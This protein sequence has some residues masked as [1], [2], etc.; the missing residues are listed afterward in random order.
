M[1]Y[2][3]FPLIAED[4]ADYF[5]A[6]SSGL[7][8]RAPD[9]EKLSFVDWVRRVR[10]RFRW[11]RHAR[12][13]AGVLQRVADGELS[14]VMIFTE[15]RIGKS[16]EVSRLFSAYFL[17][18]YPERWVGLNSYAADL[19]YTLSRAARDNYRSSGG[20]VRR[21]VEAVRHWETPEGGGMWAAGVGGPITGKGFHL[22]LIDD[23]L[24]NA[25]E[26][27]SETIR[28]G[29]KEWYRSTF[30]TREEPDGAI[31]VIQTRW[32]E[33]DLSGWLLDEE[34]VESSA[35]EG[36]PERW[37]IV[38]LP[39]IKEDD[40]QEFPPTCTVEPDWRAAG[41][42]CCPER[43]PLEKL[44]KIAR[45]VGEYFWSALFMQRPSPK[46]GTVFKRESFEVVG[47]V[48]PG[49]RYVRYW[50][51][52]GTEG[53][54]A[55]SAGVLLAVASG[56]YYVVDVVRGQWDATA[57]NAVIKQTAALDAS[58]YGRVSIWLEQ[59][60]GSGGKESAQISV[61]DL[62]GYAAFAEPVTG[63]KLFRAQPLAAQAGVRNVKLVNAPERPSLWIA[64]YL[65]ELAAFPTGKYKD[66]VD[67]SSGAFNKLA[68]VG[69]RKLRET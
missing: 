40:A 57:R 5:E 20:Q 42:A 62:A 66:Q 50:D 12:V 65:D 44:K 4:L 26:A 25:E 41:E 17:Y 35:E 24:K 43:H 54:G 21:D 52:A 45:R 58:T 48:P 38:S 69:N 60:P 14:R 55:Y 10:P 64:K 59:E 37:H 36:Q 51:K 1:T 63:D 2:P 15:P 68:L 46:G 47:A 53:G 7:P 11:Y 16:E 13:I 29:H 30:Y 18:R 3:L 9:P 22:G 32:N 33:D 39:A 67:A 23:P 49:A 19:A 6:A 28:E 8:R 61:K 56:V 27:A 31:V 34:Y